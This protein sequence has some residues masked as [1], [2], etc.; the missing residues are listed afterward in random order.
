VFCPV[1]GPLFQTIY[2]TALLNAPGRAV[3][4]A[5]LSLPVV[6]VFRPPALR[7][8]LLACFVPFGHRD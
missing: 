6:T 5:G 3:S 7:F 2:A 8:P 4:G 1:R